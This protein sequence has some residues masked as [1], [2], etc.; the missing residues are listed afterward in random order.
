MLALD[1]DVLVTWAMDGVPHHR[2]VRVLV[3]GE[4]ARRR[5]RVVLSPRVIEEFLHIATD[6][7]RFEEPFS[8]PAAI[9][10]VQST[11]ATR[12]VLCIAEQAS[13]PSR[14]LELLSQNKLGRKRILDTALAATLEAAGVR[15]L[16]TFNE[17]DFKV[18]DFIEIVDPRGR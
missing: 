6:P 13:V 18:F 2:Q 16:A 9:A 5:G 14:T 7:N 15:R 1:T 11:L 3:E 17:S 8:M 4:L 12:D 10:F